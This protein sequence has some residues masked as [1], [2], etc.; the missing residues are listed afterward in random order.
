MTPATVLITFLN[1]IFIGSAW[2][3]TFKDVQP[4]FEKRCSGCHA[5]GS[6]GNI[7]WSDYQTVFAMKEK[8]YLRV[9]ELK[10]M[11]MYTKMPQEERDLIKVWIEQGAKE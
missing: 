1:L 7:N 10:N 5:S 6:T 8:I 9:V 3:A 4:I 2:A 11:P